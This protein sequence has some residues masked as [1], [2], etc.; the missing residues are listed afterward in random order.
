MKNPPKWLE[1]EKEAMFISLSPDSLREAFWSKISRRL[2]AIM[3]H[4]VGSLLAKTDH[5]LYR[6]TNYESREVLAQLC[7][8]VVRP[9][10]PVLKR[11][12][13]RPAEVA[14]LHSLA[15][16]FY[17]PKH[18]PMGWSKGWVA[19]LHLALQWGHF[20]PA[21]IFDEHLNNECNTKEL[22]V[23]FVPGLE[24]VTEKVLDKLNQLRRRGVIIVGDEFTTPAL[25][26]DLRIKSIQRRTNDPVQTKNELQKLGRE[27]A[28][29][30]DKYAPR[31]A[32]ASNQDLVLRQRGCDQADYLFAVNDKRTFG[33]YIGQWRLVQEN[34]LP[35]SGTITLRHSAAA[36]YD[37]VAHKE[38]CLKNGKTS[39]S[40]DVELAPGDGKVILLLDRKIERLALKVPTCVK[41]KE[42]F[43][44][45]CSVLDG[46]GNPIKAY[47]PLALELKAA[48]GTILPGTG[49]YAAVNGRCTVKEV[50]ASNV[51]AGKVTVSLRCL[52]S[53]KTASATLNAEK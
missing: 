24:V 7:E 12:P 27:L 20:Q 23:L 26:V 17:A 43:D 50:M 39:C 25:L 35:N 22:K 44:I 14:I 19:D 32:V 9:L 15:A 31:R 5:K 3:Y 10:G 29:V 4:G 16:G 38:I 34:G 8:E 13:E 30:L 49:Y 2:D 51:P 6:M 42:S 46:K 1:T 48:D 11:V 33:D 47:I 28:A 40:L 53:G 52:A 41:A 18:F 45:D 36:A 21:I 37:L